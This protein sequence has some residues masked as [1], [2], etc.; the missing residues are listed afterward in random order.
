MPFHAP[1][2]FLGIC[3]QHAYLGKNENVPKIRIL[4]KITNVV[5]VPFVCTYSMRPGMWWGCQSMG[6]TYFGP[7]EKLPIEQK[8]WQFEN[9]LSFVTKSVP[10]LCLAFS[11][12]QSD[13]DGRSSQLQQCASCVQIHLG[14]CGPVHM[15]RVA[16]LVTRKNIFG[17]GPLNPKL[18]RP[19]V[20][21]APTS[22]KFPVK[23]KGC[24]FQQNWFLTVKNR[25]FNQKTQ[26]WFLRVAKM[27]FDSP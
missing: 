2:I 7:K 3:T 5:F 16:L 27:H 9:G 6:R 21:Q 1:K 12:L 18:W 10:V 14:W 19:K 11:R 23:T 8:L 24:K 13:T 15:L 20:G 26:K 25:G 22:S 4:T 17:L